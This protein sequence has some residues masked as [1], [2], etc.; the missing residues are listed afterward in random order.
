MQGGHNWALLRRTNT[1]FC[2]MRTW[3]AIL[4]RCPQPPGLEDRQRIGRSASYFFYVFLQYFYCLLEPLVCE[5]VSSVTPLHFLLRPRVVEGRADVGTN[6]LKRYFNQPSASTSL[7]A[8]Y[9]SNSP[10]HLRHAS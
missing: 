7:C 10:T 1:E 6:F 8:M 9:L 5:I 2:A 4:Q 3:E